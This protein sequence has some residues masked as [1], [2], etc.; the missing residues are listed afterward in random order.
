VESWNTDRK[1]A[2]IRAVSH[3]V[4][5]NPL[6]QAQRATASNVKDKTVRRK[7]EMAVSWQ[8]AEFY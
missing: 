1:G 4:I 6:P 2:A 7:R 5:I 8:R 3:R